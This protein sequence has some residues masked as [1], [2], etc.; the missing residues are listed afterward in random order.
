MKI[1]LDTNVLI[2]ALIKQGKPRILLTKVIRNNHKL[3]VSEDILIALARVCNDTV[4]RKYVNQRDITE[5]IRN[6]ASIPKMVERVSD[7]RVIKEDPD[8]D[9]ILQTACDARAGYIVSG[10][11]HLVTLRRYRGVRI[12]SVEEML[13]II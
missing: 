4:I 1:V 8:D 13:L 5:F 11:R 6:I 12:L 10:D 2:S 9:I 7:F 3:I